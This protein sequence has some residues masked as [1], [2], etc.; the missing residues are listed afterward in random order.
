MTL[1]LAPRRLQ[2]RGMDVEEHPG[3]STLIWSVAI[4]ALVLTASVSGL[5]G[6]ER[7]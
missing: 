5:V 3:R 4:A 6:A 7:L 1:P 2:S